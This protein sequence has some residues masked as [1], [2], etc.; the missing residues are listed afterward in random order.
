L[1]YL[2]VRGGNLY[3]ETAGEGPPL[4]LI[5]A[6]FLDC[7]MWDEQFQLFA[8]NSRAIRYD[9]RGYGRSSGPSEEYSDT[10][11]LLA[12]LKHLDTERANILGILQWR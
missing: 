12:L 7:R 9:V 4:V 8:K 11:D 6:G 1:S 10:E 5:H 3:Y 2:Q